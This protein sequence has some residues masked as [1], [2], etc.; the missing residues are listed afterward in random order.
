MLPQLAERMR[1]ENLQVSLMLGVREPAE[2]LYGAEFRAVAAANPGFTFHAC[3]SRVMPEVPAED[4]QKGYVLQALQDLDLDP[5]R[6]IVYL[7]G[8]PNMV[9]QA[10]EQL[11]AR[12]YSPYAIRREKYV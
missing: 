12:G 3:Y 7:C 11:A 2:L 4:E 1:D 5:E 9:D 10:M 8:N 6:D